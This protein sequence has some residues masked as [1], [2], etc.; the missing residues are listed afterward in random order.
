MSVI[1][2]TVVLGISLVGLTAVAHAE[3]GVSLQ[4]THV[5]PGK[6]VL[7]EKFDGT[8]LPKGWTANKGTWQPKDGT[9]VGYEKKEDMHAAVLTLAKPFK[10][11]AIRFSF[12]RDG[13]TGFNLSFNHPKGHLFRVLINDEGL[14]LNKDKDKNDPNSKPQALAKAEGKFP[15]G[16]WHTLLVEVHGDKVWVTADNGTRLEASHPGL[17]LDKTGYRFVMRGSTLLLDDVKIFGVEP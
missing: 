2:F 13:A 9:L 11:T 10:S 6:T 7:E 12:L 5:K 3:K 16:Q 1:R 4:P 15:S 17:A 8:A 14:V